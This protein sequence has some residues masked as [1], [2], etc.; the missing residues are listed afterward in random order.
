MTT[1]LFFCGTSGS[2]SEIDT[3]EKVPSVAMRSSLRR[4]CDCRN[5]APSRSSDAAEDQPLVGPDGALDDEAGDD[6]PISLRRR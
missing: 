3:L 1:R 5:G 4:A 2:S 6:H